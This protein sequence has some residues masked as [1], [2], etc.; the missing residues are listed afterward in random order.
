MRTSKNA[1]NYKQIIFLIK[2]LTL[3]LNFQNI[4]QAILSISLLTL[5]LH[6][7]FSSPLP[8]P[9]PDAQVLVPAPEPVLIVDEVRIIYIIDDLTCSF[10]NSR[11]MA[12]IIKTV[13]SKLMCFLYNCHLE[14][15][16]IKK[17]KT[18]KPKA[19]ISKKPLILINTLHFIN[20]DEVSFKIGT[21][22]R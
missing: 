9:N 20:R 19:D 4:F 6:K 5:F 8:N 16:K 11:Q 21:F 7:T 3:I 17:T 10:A 1:Y 18:Y 14:A 22:M 12:K 15:K 2:F 13:T